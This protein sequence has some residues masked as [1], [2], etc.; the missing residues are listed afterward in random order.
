MGI[1]HFFDLI[2]ALHPPKTAE[3]LKKNELLRIGADRPR[4]TAIAARQRS[5]LGA[6]LPHPEGVCGVSS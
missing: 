3:I 1:P 6:P 5:N 4:H 2:I